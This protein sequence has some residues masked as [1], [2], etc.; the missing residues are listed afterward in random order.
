MRGTLTNTGAHALAALRAE[1]APTAA[2]IPVENSG[3]PGTAGA[4]WEETSSAIPSS[5]LM[6]GFLNGP[7]SISLT[8]VQ[9]FSDIGFVVVSTVP[10]PGSFAMLIGALGIPTALRSRDQR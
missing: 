9:S 4:H 1:F 8:T 5:D 6:T 2:F 10:L 3:G 7:T